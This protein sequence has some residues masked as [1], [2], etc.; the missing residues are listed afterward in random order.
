STY[1]DL[2]GS[3][4]RQGL[5]LARAT[6]EPGARF[7]GLMAQA[8]HARASGRLG[9][10]RILLEP[11]LAEAERMRDPRYAIQVHTAIG[12]D[13]TAHGDHERALA[14]FRRAMR[15]AEALGDYSVGGPARRALVRASAAQ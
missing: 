7:F 15:D 9:S 2:A 6:G 3:F 4:A 11:L 12:Q 13:H 10:A 14:H 5:A 8:R 1:I